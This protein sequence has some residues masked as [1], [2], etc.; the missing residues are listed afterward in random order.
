METIKVVNWGGATPTVTTNELDIG[1]R[2][3]FVLD[4]DTTL[5]PIE[6][7]ELDLEEDGAPINEVTQTSELDRYGNLTRSHLETID[8]TGTYTKTIENQS[9]LT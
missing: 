4:D 6:M 3:E 5:E 2:S 8:I 7:E 9:Q 1:D